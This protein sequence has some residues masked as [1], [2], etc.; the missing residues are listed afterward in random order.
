M[1]ALFSHVGYAHKSD[2]V[3]ALK[4]FGSLGSLLFLGACI[5]FIAV[6]PDLLNFFAKWKYSLGRVAKAALGLAIVLAVFA[7]LS[8]SQQSKVSP[9]CPINLQPRGTTGVSVVFDNRPQTPNTAPCSEWILI[10]SATTAN[11]SFTVT[12][13]KAQDNGVVGCVG[14]S[15]STFSGLTL[16]AEGVITASQVTAD[17]VR[18]NLTAINSGTVSATLLGWRDNAGSIAGGAGGPCGVLGGDLS[19]TCAA[20]TVVGV[21]GAAIPLSAVVIGTYAS[22]QLVAAMTSGSGTTVPLQTGPTLNN[23]ILGGVTFAGLPAPSNG[24]E[25]YCSDCTVTSAI[26]DT[27]ANSGAGALAA[28]INGVWRCRI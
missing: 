2:G 6:L 22:R 23:P 8:Y 12:A 21:E 27:C 13:Q 9:D 19:G 20:A 14:C 25:V 5:T 7:P 10:A 18:I 4:R 24:M 3:R 11:M 15:W 16:S 17:Y 26:D 28:R 1:L